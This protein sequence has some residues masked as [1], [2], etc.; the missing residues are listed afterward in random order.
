MKTR[1]D[2]ILCGEIPIEKYPA[3]HPWRAIQIT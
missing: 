3:I 1:N 2:M